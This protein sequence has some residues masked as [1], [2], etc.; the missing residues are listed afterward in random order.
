MDKKIQRLLKSLMPALSWQ[1]FLQQNLQVVDDALV[2]QGS[3]IPLNPHKTIDVLALGKNSH[4]FGSEF[5]KRAEGRLKI[6]ISLAIDKELPENQNLKVLRG[7]H[8]V[9]ANDSY[10]SANTVL[11]L[12]SRGSERQLLVL[13]SGGASSLM[14]KPE[15]FFSSSDV[16]QL[17]QILLS[18]GASIEEINGLRPVVSM[19]KAGGLAALVPHTSI[20]TLILSDLPDGSFEKVGS[21]P[22]CFY[23]EDQTQ[24][25]NLARKYLSSAPMLQKK[26]LS[27]L[28]SQEYR[29]RLEHKHQLL[30]KKN[31]TAIKLSDWNHLKT[32]IEK[33]MIE[34]EFDPKDFS[35]T[36]EN[37]P[38]DVSLAEWCDLLRD[39]FV[40]HKGQMAHFGLGELTL[41]LPSKPGLGGRNSHFVLSLMHLLFEK[42]ILALEH[43]DLA[44]LQ[45]FSFSPDGSDGSMPA[46]GAWGNLK[47]FEK[48]RMEGIL[49]SAFLKKYDSGNYFKRVGGLITS[50][51]GQLMN[52]MDIRG[53]LKFGSTTEK[54]DN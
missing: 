25:S 40:F 16:T 13:L 5:L 24:L 7:D 8:P 23:W 21:G 27:Y 12:L 38:M 41:E 4:A 48:A 2:W 52:L 35:I 18:C 14:E 33:V 30:A 32:A 39:K 6:G 49:P 20:I 47:L 26:I 3:S 28:E 50:P 45:V 11:E 53:C 15:R 34:L 1:S 46:A 17:A 44:R 51:A 54:G 10:Q 37:A 36:L 19:L 29:E 22:T 43:R 31:L 42:N 9:P